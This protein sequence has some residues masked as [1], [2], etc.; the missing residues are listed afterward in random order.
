MMET[1]SS[2]SV[3]KQ[4]NALILIPTIL[5]LISGMVNSAPHEE[6]AQSDNTRTGHTGGDY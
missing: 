1:T 2:C 3:I 6:F 5:S 4:R